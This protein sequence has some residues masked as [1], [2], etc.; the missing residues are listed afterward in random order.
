MVTAEEYEKLSLMAIPV[1]MDWKMSQK[2]IPLNG[3]DL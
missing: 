3:F 1:G 2:K